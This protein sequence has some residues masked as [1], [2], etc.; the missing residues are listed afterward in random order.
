LSD[1]YIY[2]TL[3][4]TKE[5]FIPLRPGQVGLYVCGPT[6]YDRVHLGN[7]RCLLVFDVLY[8]L[9]RLFF[10][11]V[12]YVRN[13]TDIDDKIMQRA[14]QENI[15]V[16]TLT[17]KTL[18]WFL[19]DVRALGLLDPKAQPR[20]TDF[21]PNMIMMI[22]DLMH[23]KAAYAVGG[24]VF[25]SV[26][27]WKKYGSLCRMEMDQ[28]RSG[29]RVAVD[30][31]KKDPLD[32]V[33][34]KP[35]DPDQEGWDSP[36]GRGR[37]GWHI[38]CSAMSS[39]FLGPTFDIHGGGRDLLFPHHENERAQTGVAFEGKEC[40]RYWMHTGMLTVDGKKMS[41]SLG[42]FVTLHDALTHT[43]PEV[44]FWALLSSHYRHGLD[45]NRAILHGAWRNVHYVYNALEKAGIDTLVQDEWKQEHV[46]CD[47]LNAL[48]DDMNTPRALSALH[49][50]ASCVHKDPADDGLAYQLL[51]SAQWLGVVQR[52]PLQWFQKDAVY[53]SADMIENM[54]AQRN[55]ARQNKDYDQADKMR[56]D[57]E[58]L[59]IIV[60]DTPQGTKWHRI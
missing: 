35:S 38:E 54:I 56:K 42:N 23:K 25:F 44:L 32:F 28:M 31:L 46:N 24:H 50:L 40:S 2:N 30:D 41:K 45:W 36:W 21:I 39:H 18:S 43:R 51:C 20:A 1:L 8:R 26:R 33:L 16:H 13:I 12:V 57:L 27:S 37:P 5:K 15:D 49:Q 6:I 17:Q 3:S 7:V 4:K 58:S 22:Q 60:E 53:P 19:Q 48:C 34:W 11:D 52:T 10:S 9:L 47:V 59:N 55:R 29:A 14:H